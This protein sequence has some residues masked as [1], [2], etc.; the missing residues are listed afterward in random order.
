MA[1]KWSP[2]EREARGEEE[3]QGLEAACARA[4][5]LNLSTSGSRQKGRAVLR[6]LVFTLREL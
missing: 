2:E 1:F 4:L 5:S 3:P 6:R